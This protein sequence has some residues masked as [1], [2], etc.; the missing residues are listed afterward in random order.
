MSAIID[1]WNLSAFA[2]VLRF[3]KTFFPPAFLIVYY[4][5]I[6]TALFDSGFIHL[7]FKSYSAFHLFLLLGSSIFFKK[8]FASSDNSLNYSFYWAFSQLNLRIELWIFFELLPLNGGLPIRRIQ[9]ITPMLQISTA[10]SYFSFLMI[11]GAIYRGVP[12]TRS[13]PP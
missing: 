11:S 10:L 1:C 4:L 12:R 8:S 5:F 3:S 9:V 7:W 6:Q 2:K 13:N